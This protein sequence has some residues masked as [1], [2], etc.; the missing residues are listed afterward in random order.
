MG[1]SEKTGGWKSRKDYCKD[2][3]IPSSA[4][5]SRSANCNVT[6]GYKYVKIGKTSETEH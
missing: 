4:V 6:G 3:V 5:L 1:N 2:I